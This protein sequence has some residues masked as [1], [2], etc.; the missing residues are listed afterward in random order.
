MVEPQ[1]ESFFTINSYNG[2]FFFSASFLRIEEEITS[3]A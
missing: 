3:V 1:G 2:I